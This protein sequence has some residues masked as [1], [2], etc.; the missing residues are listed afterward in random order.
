MQVFRIA[1]TQYIHDLSGYGASLRGGRWN[2]P[3]VYALYT[4]SSIALSAWEVRVYLDN[5]FLPRDDLYSLAFINIPDTSIKEVN[6]TTDDWKTDS[7]I[8][9]KIGQEWIDEQKFLCLKVPSAIIP[10]EYNFIVNPAH[11][12]MNQVSIQK[13]ELFV[14][15]P[16]TFNI[17]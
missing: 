12:E 15:D 16:R 3:G 1:E 2:D 4:G 11:P 5:T 10:F 8:T 17:N 14:F 9:R 13:A 7:I 6:F